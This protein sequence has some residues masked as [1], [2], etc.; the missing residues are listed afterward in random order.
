MKPNWEIFY[1]QTSPRQFLFYISKE[2]WR[3]SK[4]Y[5][6]G[7]LLSDLKEINPNQ[8]KDYL[9]EAY[10]NEEATGHTRMVIR[11]IMEELYKKPE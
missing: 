1:K 10:M 6:R 4:G 9:R 3:F 11:E 7:H 2:G 5:F 8:L